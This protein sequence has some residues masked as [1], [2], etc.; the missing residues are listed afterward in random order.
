MIWPWVTLALLGAYHGVNPGMGWLFAVSR[1]LQ[2]KRGGAVAGALPPIALGH[3]LSIGLTLA[4]VA[5]GRFSFGV[6]PTRWVAAIV[7]VAFGI[8]KL[9]RHRHPRWVGMRVGFASLFAWSFLM[10]SAH[11]AG[12]MLVPLFVTGAMGPACHA[13][14]G[15]SLSAPSG[16]VYAALVHTGAM[17]AAASAIAFVVYYRVGVAILRRA[18]F[19]LDRVWAAAL[20]ISGVAALLA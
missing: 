17:L 8:A 12:L 10:A 2:E 19:N 16:Y 6:A 13:R 15:L 5:A 1:G 11:G 4:V 18:W 20:V 3:A 14:A 7:L 9:V